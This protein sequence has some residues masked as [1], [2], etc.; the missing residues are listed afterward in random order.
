M[1]KEIT[2]LK[3]LYQK[4]YE[5]DADSIPIDSKQ[6]DEAIKEQLQLEFRWQELYS[7]ACYVHD[8]A[9]TETER[10]LGEVVHRLMA[11]SPR[12]WGFQESKTIGANEPEYINAKIKENDVA[13]IRRKIDAVV[14]V[15]ESRKYA[16]KN[17]TDL[18]LASSEKHII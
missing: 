4:L 12:S 15:I 5:Q 13:A 1:I 17:M 10:V 16:L 18:V 11:E 9:K 3:N 6:I 7:Y 14:K 8:K 2:K